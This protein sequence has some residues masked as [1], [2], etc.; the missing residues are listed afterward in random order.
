MFL[1]PKVVRCIHD[2]MEY[3]TYAHL[4]PSTAVL[5]RLFSDGRWQERLV[6]FQPD[7]S[8]LYA[9]PQ[10]QLPSW[11][12]YL[13]YNGLYYQRTS[14]RLGV[15]LYAMVLAT[16]FSAF[17]HQLQ[18][19]QSFP[20]SG[21]LQ[22]D[23]T[24]DSSQWI[25][26]DF[27]HGYDPLSTPMANTT[28]LRHVGDHQWRPSHRT[29]RNTPRRPESMLSPLNA[30]N[31]AASHYTPL[32]GDPLDHPLPTPPPP[33]P[34]ATAAERDRV[35]RQDRPETHVR[36]RSRSPVRPT[37]AVAMHAAAAPA[38][39]KEDTPAHTA[40]YR[41]ALL[42]LP[43]Y[44]DLT[45]EH[46]VQH[47]VHSGGR[48]ANTG[49]RD[50]EGWRCLPASLFQDH[51]DAY[52]KAVASTK[53][54]NAP[55][56]AKHYSER[57]YAYAQPQPWQSTMPKAEDVALALLRPSD[58]QRGKATAHPTPNYTMDT[59]HKLETAM[60]HG[61]AMASALD[62]HLAAAQVANSQLAEDLEQLRA[63]IQD[64][65]VLEA[66]DRSRQTL[67]H[68]RSFLENCGTNCSHLSR[69]VINEACTM[70]L[71]RRDAYLTNPPETLPEATIKLLR[72]APFGQEFLFGPS[73]LLEA[74]RT[75]NLLT[76]QQ[77][78]ALELQKIR[79]DLSSGSYKQSF[80]GSRGGR[81]GRSGGRGGRGRGRGGRGGG[82]GGRGRGGRGGGG[83]S[84]YGKRNASSKQDSGGSDGKDGNK[85]T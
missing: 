84:S 59:C 52:T 56:I 24:V 85:A 69:L 43:D 10:L 80:R 64:P 49:S 29:P 30:F 22:P 66:V 65:A 18:R 45:V 21:A 72:C 12:L 51:F 16:E 14:L 58:K 17:V 82:G 3:A 70:Q 67:T 20:P 54:P 5:A 34:A 2:R 32:L 46:R 1:S 35:A 42:L 50:E 77:R 9:N 23:A 48:A 19:I 76:Q 41:D 71:H 44:L 11:P 39:P 73:T 7:G 28:G 36:D 40:Q 47:Q 33:P 61:V 83:F 62:T 6:F 68:A 26:R 4:P 38:V 57:T 13:W 31:S 60:W 27:H 37:R 78:D 63:S 75:Q 15:A 74:N 79:N 8:F 81:G 53:A 25:N 55:A